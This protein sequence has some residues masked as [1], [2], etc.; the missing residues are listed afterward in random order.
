MAKK[1]LA[2]RVYQ[3]L[4][5]RF[6][7]DPGHGWAEVPETLFKALDLTEYSAQR[8]GKMYLEEDCELADLERAAKKAGYKLTLVDCYVD[9]FDDWIEGDSW[10]QIPLMED[11]K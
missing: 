1:K 9:S 11:I 2:K 10:P 6:I 4:E 3:K 7:G 5:L 8:N